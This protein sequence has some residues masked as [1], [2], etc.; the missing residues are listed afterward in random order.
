MALPQ[1]QFLNLPQIDASIQQARANEVQNALAPYM[2]QKA[3]MDAEKGG[4]ELQ[5]FREDVARQKQIRD[6]LAAQY[7]TRG[8][9]ALSPQSQPAAQAPVSYA[10]PD[11][12]MS[13]RVAAPDWMPKQSPQLQQPQTASAQEL[14][15]RARRAAMLRSQAEI[16]AKNGDVTTANALEDQALKLEPKWNTDPRYDQ[17]GNAFLVNEQG[18][19]KLLTGVKARDKIISDDIGGSKIFRTEYST[20]PLSTIDKTLTP[21]AILTDNRTRS[22]GALNRGVTVRGQDLTNARAKEHNDIQAGNKQQQGAIELRKEFNALPEVKNYKEVLP[23]VQSV[24]RAPDT[25]AGDIDLIY[26]VGKV[27]DP[28]SVV[29]EGELNLVIKAGSPAQRLM[30]YVNYV[31]GGG[32]L[33]QDQRKDLMVVMESRTAGLKSNYDAARATY[34]TAADKQG[35]PK[36]QIFIESPKPVDNTPQKPGG[37]ISANQVQTPDGQIRTFPTKQQADA[38]RRAAGL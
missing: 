38:F 2:L 21:E 14:D 24:Q 31:K 29:R 28:N 9:T 25:P 13:P 1:L 3:Q 19:T 27:M 26:G 4:L 34:E 5:K 18:G 36:D 30:G 15:V 35:L 6:E 32:R 23:I 22:E 10:G 33:T 16:Y 20:T 7:A 37:S 11:N 17:N 8:A 12:P